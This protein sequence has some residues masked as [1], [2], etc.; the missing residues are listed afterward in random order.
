MS[1]NIPGL[2]SPGGRFWGS[3]GWIPR[4]S[5][6]NVRPCSCTLCIPAAWTGRGCTVTIRV[7]PGAAPTPAGSPFHWFR[8]ERSDQANIVR[9]SSSAAVTLPF[10]V[11]VRVGE[12]PFPVIPWNRIAVTSSSR[13]C[14]VRRSIATRE[15]S[16]EASSAASTRHNRW[17]H[18]ARSP[19][20]PQASHSSVSPGQSVSL[21]LQGRP[22]LQ[23]SPRQ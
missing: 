18:P 10:M 15:N 12:P 16:S 4:W 1:G 2:P 19:G 3:G 23:G 6:T 13:I 21:L 17:F 8:T 20:V 11:H 9:Y 7:F 5:R 22:R 14:G